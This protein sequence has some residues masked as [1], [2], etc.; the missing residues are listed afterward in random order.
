MSPPQG[1]TPESHALAS[2]A[3]DATE[4][5]EVNKQ[6]EQ[7]RRAGCGVG[8]Y[9]PNVELNEGVKRRNLCTF[10]LLIFFNIS[11]FVLMNALQP[12]VL[13]HL[14][15]NEDSKLGTSTILLGVVNEAIIVLSSNFWG[16]LS[17]KSGRRVVY[18]IGFVL[19]GI[20]QILS[21]FVNDFGLLL[22][23]RVVFAF[24]ASATSAMMMAV[25][26]DY[27]IGG[28]LGRSSGWLGVF[29]GCGALFSALVLMKAPSWFRPA[30]GDRGGV[31]ATYV[32]SGF[33]S[34]VG[35]SAAL[36]GLKGR[37]NPGNL[38]KRDYMVIVKEGMTAARDESRLALSYLG[39]FVARGD[40]QVLTVFLSLWIQSAYSS[41][42]DRSALAGEIS[43]IGQSCALI[44]AP[45]VGILSDRM[46]RTLAM[47]YMSML[48]AAG[49]TL[50][51]FLPDPA[52]GAAMGAVCLVGVGEI[53]VIVTSLSLAAKHAPKNVRGSV[54]GCYGLAGSLGILVCTSGG[55]A[56]F[57]TMNG[58]P[59]LLFGMFSAVTAIWGSVVYRR[60]KASDQLGMSLLEE[61]TVVTDTQYA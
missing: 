27:V 61:E 44:A 4:P 16:A 34:F 30:F 22:A 33:F 8:K 31:Q 41:N 51:A 13:Q 6:M 58:S 9:T 57:S 40:S 3:A 48:A 35:A 14:G 52:G 49:Y 42:P 17:D 43:G 59:F 7:Q 11:A 39:G 15:I 20:G 18:S 5:T 45:F 28:E 19:L 23:C 37:S 53:G 50:F 1:P 24:G 38:Q 46:D 25:L 47:V 26:S 54:S 29:S 56:L 21:P 55:G 10:Y 2:P 36:V 60:K 32:L 12:N